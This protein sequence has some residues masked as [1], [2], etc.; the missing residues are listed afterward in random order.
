ML[1]NLILP[2][3]ISPFVMTLAL[4]KEDVGSSESDGAQITPRFI[5]PLSSG[6]NLTFLLRAVQPRDEKTQTNWPPFPFFI[7]RTAA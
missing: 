2:D 5:L 1:V 7:M 4:A 6:Y 3:N